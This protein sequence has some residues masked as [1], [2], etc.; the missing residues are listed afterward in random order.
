MSYWWVNHKQTY[1]QE[2]NGGYIWCPKGKKDG[3]PNHFYDN[4]TLAK[5]GDIVFSYANGKIGAIGPVIKEHTTA[6]RPPEFGTSGQ[7]WDKDGW[8]VQ[9]A[10]TVLDESLFPNE[11]F[12]EI[13]DLLPEK[14]SP[15]N[16][17]GSGNQG[18]YLASIGDDLGILLISKAN[19]SNDR[20]EIIL[21][22]EEERRVRGQDIPETEKEQLVKSRRGQG[23]FRNRLAE[24]EDG[25]RLTGVDDTR[26][27]IASHIKPWRHCSNQEKLDGNNGLFLSPHVDK[28]FDRGWITFSREGNIL[29][30]GPQIRLIMSYWNLDPTSNVGSF[31]E[32]QNDYL[33]HHRN[34]IYQGSQKEI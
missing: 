4:L 16:Q 33:S 30:A 13:K 21:D 27:L 34:T 28:L 26:F 5:S 14:Y 32:A 8:L 7:L 1:K 18:C 9:I 20:V 19:D 17:E 15:I 11:F 29:C 10:W 25:C 22:D 3:N 12:N 31:S 24:I 23:I 6:D 2:I